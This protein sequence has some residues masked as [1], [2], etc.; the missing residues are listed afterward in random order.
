[1][2][3]IS[4]IIPVA[5]EGEDLY[6]RISLFNEKLKILSL[7]YGF[8]YEII[9]VTDVFHQPTIKALMKLVIERIAICFILT[10]RIGKGGSIKNVIP[11]AKGDLIVLLDA[12][13]PV[14]S[15]MIYKV[16]SIAFRKGVDLLIASR[17]YREHTILRR[18]LSIAFNAIVNQL[19]RTKLNDHQAGFKILSKKA[20]R[21]ILIGRTRSE[22]FAYDTEVIVW[23]KKHN[24]RF[25]TIKV[26]W[27]ECRKKPV[28]S[29]FRGLLTMVLDLVLLMLFSI[30]GKYIALK[31]IP[32]GHV[33]DLSCRCVRCYEY[34][35]VV[36]VSGFKK[37][38]FSLLRLLYTA[39]IVGIKNENTLDKS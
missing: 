31:R 13:L 7:K 15:E 39:L 26:V 1:M 18:M 5:R 24:L 22:G 25:M 33:I 6:N 3:M 28:F 36:N 23:A 38:I 35:T 4:I 9:V 8:R 27:K 11:F 21:I 34:M 12:D 10:A 32:I 30:S 19:F 14:S 2:P 16:S 20:A 37:Y 17:V 29:M